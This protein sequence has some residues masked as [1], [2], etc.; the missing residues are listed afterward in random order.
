MCVCVCMNPPYLMIGLRTTLTVVWYCMFSVN[1]EKAWV[2]RYVAHDYSWFTLEETWKRRAAK[3]SEPKNDSLA[4]M[5]QECSMLFELLCLE[6][7][8]KCF[9]HENLTCFDQNPKV[10]TKW[11]LQYK[12]SLFLTCVVMI[13]YCKITFCMPLLLSNGIIVVMCAEDERETRQITGF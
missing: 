2:A 8:Q 4:S 3:T 7:Q 5:N 6:M 11:T 9:H 12:A 1:L 10:L 13:H